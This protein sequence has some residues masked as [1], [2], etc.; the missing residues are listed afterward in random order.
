MSELF[1]DLSRVVGSSLPRR[2]ALRL[3]A[4]ALAGAALTPLGFWRKGASAGTTLSLQVS[5]CCGIPG[6]CLMT[7]QQGCTNLG[8]QFVSGG[9]CCS[10]QPGCFVPNGPS[11]CC[12]V[13]DGCILDPLGPNHCQ[14][15]VVGTPY[16][17]QVCGHDETGHGVCCPSSGQLP[18]GLCCPPNRQACNNTCCPSGQACIN[19]TCC[20]AGGTCSDNTCCPPPGNPLRTMCCGGKCCTPSQ[21]CKG[22]TTCC[23]P[24]TEKC[25]NDCCVASP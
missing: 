13:P 22:G 12:Q 16:P 17:N 11:V 15:C 23:N 9:Q 19:S 2:E 3:V 5:G 6:Q 25:E 24:N 20:P 4:S 21:C 7:S 1:D 10:N 14:F 8:G 18:S